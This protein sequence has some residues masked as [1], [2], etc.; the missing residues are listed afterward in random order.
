MLLLFSAAAPAPA[1]A[2]AP[3]HA[4][5]WYG[6]L[7]AGAEDALFFGDG[8]PPAEESANQ[9]Q[10]LELQAQIA[11]LQAQML[12]LGE[13]Y[14]RLRADIFWPDV[15]HQKNQIDQGNAAV[16]AFVGGFLGQQIQPSKRH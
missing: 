3:S 10:I 13:R 4:P 8:E 6:G 1:P 9:T 11:E 7:V 16:L 5:F 2:P 14:S 12:A 15:N